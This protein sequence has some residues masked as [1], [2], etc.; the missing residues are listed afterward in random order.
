M[1]PT[2]LIFRLLSFSFSRIFLSFFPFYPFVF[3]SLF[4]YN[5]KNMSSTTN[6]TT[7]KNIPKDEWEQ[8]LTKVKVN[9][10]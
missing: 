10:Q 7:K 1:V 2:R 4:F 3:F 6:N 5:N 8:R 9:K